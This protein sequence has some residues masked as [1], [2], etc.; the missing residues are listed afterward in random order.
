MKTVLTGAA[1]GILIALGATSYAG[2]QNFQNCADAEAAGFT[3][4]PRGSAGYAP[5]L[6]RDNDGVACESGTDNGTGVVVSDDDLPM[7][8]GSQDAAMVIGGALVAG[9]ASWVLAT[10]GRRRPA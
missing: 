2:A 6:D 10:R 7:T 5:R 4:I 8:G 9:G 3:D 1:V